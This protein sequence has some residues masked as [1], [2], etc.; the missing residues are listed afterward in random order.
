MC[1]V[2]GFLLEKLLPWA[3]E[4]VS[5]FFDPMEPCPFLFYGFIGS[6]VEV[7][8]CVKY[9]AATDVDLRLFGRLNCSMPVM[10]ILKE[11][12]FVNKLLLAFPF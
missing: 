2:P 8:Q 12:W 11:L 5:G 3:I 9:Y 7:F 4:L 1:D 6:A 10:C